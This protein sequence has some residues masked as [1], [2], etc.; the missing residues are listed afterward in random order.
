MIVIPIGVDCGNAE[1]L[2]QHNLR[3]CSL[4]FDWVVTYNGVSKIIKNNFV[5]F[6]PKNSDSQ[7]NAEYDTAFIHNH[8]PQDTEKVL[9]RIDRLKNILET[10]REPVIFLRKGHAPHLH[11]EQNGR[12]TNHMKSDIADA[13]DLDHV[14]Q[15]K[16][17][18]LKYEIVVILVCGNCFDP[19]IQYSTESKNI[20]VYNIATSAA[21]DK[22]Y[23]DLCQQIF[24]IYI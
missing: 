3:K 10:T 19:T 24:N 15:E 7:F 20:K 23:N 21:D 16:Y 12:Y 8:F 9:R 6:L 18:H 4:P 22:K 2:Q 1:F 11:D 14:L 17:P 13:E 5:D